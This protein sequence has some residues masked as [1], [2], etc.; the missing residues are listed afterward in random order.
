MCF[1]KEKV[2]SYTADCTLRAPKFE[3]QRI[4]NRYVKMVILSALLPG[5]LYPQEI[6][7]ILIA[8]R[9]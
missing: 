7:L 4:S 3:A 1:L 9:G 6:K 8:V 5:R 2:F